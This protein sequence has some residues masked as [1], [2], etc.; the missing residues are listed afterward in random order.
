MDVISMIGSGTDQGNAF[1]WRAS[2]L[3]CMMMNQQGKQLAA[4]ERLEDILKK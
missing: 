1:V 4:L 2:T 3:V